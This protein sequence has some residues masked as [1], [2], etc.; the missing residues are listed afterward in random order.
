MKA[1]SRLR[2]TPAAPGIAVAPAWRHRSTLAGS[3]SGG[4]IGLTIAQAADL[5]AAQLEALADRVRQAG[6][7]EEADIF[8]AQALMAT[9]PLIVEEAERIA[10]DSQP[11][12]ADGL[13][14]AVETA[15]ATAAARLSGLDNEVL[16]A[17]A[18]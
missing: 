8:E 12:T 7:P 17:R 2:G 1:N 6:R 11:S 5:A 9:D 15:A 4:S 14:A 13:A 18:T 16:A 3:V 10:R